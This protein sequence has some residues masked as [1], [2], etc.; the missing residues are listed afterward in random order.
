VGF[1]VG[2]VSIS[3]TSEEVQRTKMRYMATE[4]MPVSISST[5]EEVQS[6]LI[7]GQT[8]TTTTFSFH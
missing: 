3:S 8:T 6:I 1:F 7:N 5:S 2:G 4:L